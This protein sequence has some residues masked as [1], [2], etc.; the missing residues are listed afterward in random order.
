MDTNDALAAKLAHQI[1]FM[2]GDVMGMHRAGT[3]TL[4]RLP[5]EHPAR[6]YLIGCVAFATEELGAFR[7]AERLAREAAALNA[8]DVWAIH[9]VAHVLEMTGR[10]EAGA[11]WIE[12]QRPNWQGCGNLR[13]HL[14]WHLALFELELGRRERALELYDQ[15]IRAHRTDDYRDIANAV[16]LL[17][18]LELEGVEVGTRWEELADL[19]TARVD[20]D[21][22]VF[23]RLHYLLALL[24][25]GRAR[26][27][28]ALIES[29]RRSA[30]SVVR[31]MDGVARHPGLAIARALEA[32]EFGRYAEAAALLEAAD[33]RLGALGGS[34]AQRDLFQRH[35]VEA[36]LRAGRG[37][38]AAELIGRR[39]ALRGGVLDGFAAIRI[40]RSTAAVR[41]S[42]DAGSTQGERSLPA[43]LVHSDR[44]RR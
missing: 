8:D 10:A 5:A 1:R 7:D 31:E 3:R 26:P 36:S 30:A 21:A 4:A 9:A 20:D 37:E 40:S 35:A 14:A 25:A 32:F 18:R 27:A 39:R 34:I 16:S 44:L 13:F 38:L 11:R 28:A 17:G 12:A 41:V 15:E 29:M 23:A 2:V 43:A 24:R 22:V 19:S 33:G 42:A 6:G